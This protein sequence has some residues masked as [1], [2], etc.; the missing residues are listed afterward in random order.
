MVFSVYLPRVVALPGFPLQYITFVERK[1]SMFPL[2]LWIQF[3]LLYLFIS[4]Y[5][6]AG[7]S[8]LSLIYIAVVV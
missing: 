3:I 6:K 2:R 5:L 7:I 1:A 8:A 4:F